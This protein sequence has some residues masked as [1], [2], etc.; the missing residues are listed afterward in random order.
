[1]A[2][3]SKYSK[4]GVGTL[5]LALA[6]ASGQPTDFNSQVTKGVIKPSTKVD[7]AI[8]FLNGDSGPGNIEESYQVEVDFVQNLT[9][10]G[11][12]GFLW[13]HRGKAATLVYTPNTE[14]GFKFTA[15]TVI[16]A[17]ETGGEVGKTPVVSH[18]FECS[19]VTVALASK[20]GGQNP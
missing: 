4:I 2:I 16:V 15:N 20:A 3:N 12:A 5:T 1:M 7:P 19:G 6:G 9:N 14:D 13:E 18:T 10:K 8:Q 11:L 17:P